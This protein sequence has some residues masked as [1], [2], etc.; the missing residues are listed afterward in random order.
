MENVR[1]SYYLNK[2][3][4]V[5]HGAGWHQRL[6]QNVRLHQKALR[7]SRSNLFLIQKPSH[8]K[9]IG[10]SEDGNSVKIFSFKE[11]ES[12]VLLFSFRHRNYHSF[13]RQVFFVLF[14]WIC[15]D[16]KSN[17]E[18]LATKLA[19]FF[20]RCSK[21]GAQS[22][23]ISLNLQTLEGKAALKIKFHNLVKM[24]QRRW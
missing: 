18:L 17:K 10:W 21:K 1:R 12:K 23:F 4:I 16:L 14:S 24:I 7:N 6:F 20:T 19:P 2:I 11:L 9:I 22:F 8:Q 15:M 3:R 5:E 13:I